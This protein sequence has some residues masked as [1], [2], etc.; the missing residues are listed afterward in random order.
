MSSETPETDTTDDSTVNLD[1]T[2]DD[3]VDEATVETEEVKV[4]GVAAKAKAKA[5]AREAEAAADRE[6]TVSARTLKRIVAGVVGVAVVV[7]IAFGGWAL[8]DTKR[9]LAAFDD[10]QS[11]ASAFV[12][13]YFE[14]LFSK[15]QSASALK[16]AVLPMTTGAF[17]DRV[18]KDSQGAVDFAKETKIDNF[19]TKVTSSSVKTFSKDRAVVVIAVE[20]KGT[21]ATAPTGGT[22][23]ALVQLTVDKVDGDWLVSDFAVVPGVPNGASTPGAPTA[24]APAPQPGG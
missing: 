23:L 7:A 17:H 1:K 15:D 10:S 8:F 5:Q 9:E 22:N 2:G 12:T 19:T 18:E 14:V 6:F 16:D 20:L 3:I 21:S 24:P 11:A 4:S 13:K